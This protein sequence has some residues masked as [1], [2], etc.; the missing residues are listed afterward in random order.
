MGSVIRIQRKVITKKS[1]IVY[2]RPQITG[3]LAS[4]AVYDDV[5]QR[6]NN[7]YSIKPN[8]PLVVQELIDAYTLKYNN[9][10]GNKIRLTNYVGGAP[11]GGR[12]YLIDHLTGL[13]WYQATAYDVRGSF[14]DLHGIGGRLE[15]VYNLGNLV[16]DP[17]G[18]TDYRIPNANEFVSVFTVDWVDGVDSG[19]ILPADIRNQYLTS[20]TYGSIVANVFRVSYAPILG[21][22]LKTTDIPTQ[23]VRN[24]Y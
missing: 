22:I 7:P 4:Y 19:T 14:N 3:Q 9:E 6:V 11:N 2:Q 8:S 17:V 16:G 21:N 24:H 5:W 12:E 1:G 15:T 10:F 23:L 20:T 18:F 13:G